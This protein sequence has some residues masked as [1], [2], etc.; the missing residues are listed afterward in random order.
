MEPEEC[1]PACP[2]PT[3]TETTSHP[4][5]AEALVRRQIPAQSQPPSSDAIAQAGLSG[6]AAMPSS[7]PAPGG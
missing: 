3:A 1:L 2:T 4:T 7:N 5:I 6:D